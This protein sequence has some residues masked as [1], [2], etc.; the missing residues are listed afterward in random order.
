MAKARAQQAK[1][2]LDGTKKDKTCVRALFKASCEWRQPTG[3]LTPLGVSQTL[4]G[5]ELR[6]SWLLVQEVELRFSQPPSVPSS[7]FQ[8]TSN[9]RSIDA[10]KRVGPRGGGR[11]SSLLYTRAEPYPLLSLFYNFLV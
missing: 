5:S 10:S 11:N 8:P 2:T 4:C 3:G 9:R 1:R 7:V 6:P